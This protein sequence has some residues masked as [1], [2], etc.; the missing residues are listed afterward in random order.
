MPSAAWRRFSVGRGG[1][2]NLE[3]RKKNAFKESVDELTA[4]LQFIS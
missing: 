2:K 4:R 3:F 1:K